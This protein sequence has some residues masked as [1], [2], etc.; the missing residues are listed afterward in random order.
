M[1]Y[2]LT[3]V[4][5]SGMVCWIFRKTIMTV[6][7]AARFLYR[8]DQQALSSNIN[9]D[10]YYA[11]NSE[12]KRQGIPVIGH[13][14]VGLQLEDLYQSG[15]SQ[16]AHIDSITHNLMNEFGGLSSANSE[17]FIS[18]INEL[19]DTIAL[20]LKN[21]NIALASTVCLHQTRPRQ[22]FELASFLKSIPLAYQN[23]GWLEGSVVSRGCLPGGNSY[24]N[25]HNTDKQ[26]IKEWDVYYR[27]YNQ[28]I[29]LVTQ[30]LLRHKVT[31]TAGTDALGACGM[32]AGFSLHKELQA[33]NEMGLTPS[34]VLQT[35]TVSAADWMK[36]QTGKIAAS[37][38]ADLVFLEANPLDDIGNTQKINA[39]MANGNYWS[40][41][42]LDAMLEAVKKANNNSREIAIK[43]YLNESQP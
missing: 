15:Q 35:A 12:A 4:L 8:K 38:R 24:E 21:N 10:V 19:A 41:D 29:K 5:A 16:L 1:F 20:N 13:L 42:Q 9:R 37:Y 39:V 30:A 40:R 25:P 3:S 32:I 36:L 6:P 43:E 22:D 2:L 17:A 31:I 14:P 23:P 28:A 26:S 27:A 11:I 33:L 18:H 34:Q 7:N